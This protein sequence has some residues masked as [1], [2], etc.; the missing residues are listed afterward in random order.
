MICGLLI[1]QYFVVVRSISL[2]VALACSPQ[3]EVALC[4]FMERIFRFF[5]ILKIRPVRN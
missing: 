3:T 4:I 1:G 2:R 5:H